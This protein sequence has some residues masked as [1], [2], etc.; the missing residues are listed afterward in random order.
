M[1][2]RVPKL[3]NAAV[4][5]LSLAV[6]GCLLIT[7]LDDFENAT[8]AAGKAGRGGSSG[9]DAGG[10]AGYGDAAGGSPA[11]QGG[12]PSEGGESGV[13]GSMPAGAGGEA[14]ATPS[15]CRTN[16]ECVEA[17]AGEPY[18][19]HSDGSCVRLKTNECPLVYGSFE[20]PHA[21]YVGSFAPLPNGAPHTSA[22]VYAERLALDEF[23]RD[24]GLPGP[25]G[26][27]HPIVM[28]VCDNESSSS[29][30]AGMTHL[31]DQVEVPGVLSM[32]LP[33]D[34][35]AVFTNFKQHGIFYL[36]PV[37]ATRAVVRLPDDDLV[38][39][40]LGQPSDLAPVYVEL[41]RL[42]E[43]RLRTQRAL[44]DSDRIRVAL[45][46]TTDAFNSELAAYVA[47]DLE[48]NGGPATTDEEHYRAFTVTLDDPE[49]DQTAAAVGDAVR[50]F[51]PDI[52]ISTAGEPFTKSQG[53]F[54]R[55]EAN[56]LMTYDDQ[57]PRPFHVLSP[58]NA[59]DLDR[60]KALLTGLINPGGEPTDALANERV[61]GIEAAGALD[62]T[63]QNQYASRLLA[64]YRG[65]TTD[66][67]NYYDAFYYLAYAMYGAGAGP[68]LTG[69]DILG[70]MNSLLTGPSHD[71]G[72]PIQD[73]LDAI[74][75][76][77]IEL[78]GT[79]GPPDFDLDGGIRIDAG[80]V[81]CIERSGNLLNKSP[82]A[83]RY[84]RTSR[85]L[86][87]SFPCF[88]GFPPP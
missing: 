61:L 21:I 9:N 71:I 36:N 51:K 13:A 5:S 83:L 85:E 12:V 26:E 37:G 4:L 68:N 3:T 48:I 33:A 34:M 18:R 54:E 79:L 57:T 45:V 32:L 88:D 50:E 2:A 7:P 44:A 19:C 30:M 14:G 86:E 49:P 62:P 84:N 63:L 40:I 80:S 28:V 43:I 15:G 59:G 16:A 56:W 24:G 52:V 65:A 76:S 8:P 42:L 78:I 87:G 23:N 73:V 46:T 31:A 35:Q 1:K 6:G 29:V 82:D 55:I 22:V 25:D 74:D 20:D 77:S 67:G 72:P 10:E 66:S 27:R 38:W 47:E 39:N 11:G 81:F 64:A 53:V 60:L 17:G 75:R 41:V 69:S 70:G 58:F